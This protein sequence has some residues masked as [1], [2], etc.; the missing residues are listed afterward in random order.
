MSEKDIKIEFFILEDDPSFKMIRDKERILR[1]V[2]N[3][4]HE[5]KEWYYEM[6]SKGNLPDEYKKF[7]DEVAEWC[8]NRDWTSYN[9]YKDKLWSSYLRRLIEGKGETQMN[10]FLKRCKEKISREI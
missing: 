5:L 4:S 8:Q 6:G 2:G 10:V 9:K 1:I 3:G 7:K